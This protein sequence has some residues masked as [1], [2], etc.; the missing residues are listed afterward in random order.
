ME[1]RRRIP[2]EG[3]H[4]HNIFTDIFISIRQGLC[5]QDGLADGAY[6]LLKQ[7]IK[8]VLGQDRVLPG[9]AQAGGAPDRHRPS[10]I[11]L[12]ECLG[13]RDMPRVIPIYYTT[14]VREGEKP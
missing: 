10:P 6:T 13:K 12:Q 3:V 5:L 7:D 8:Q 1:P 2:E 4:M 11:Q 14:L 9:I